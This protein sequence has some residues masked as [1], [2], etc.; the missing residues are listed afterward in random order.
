MPKGF[1][2]EVVA[3]IARSCDLLRLGRTMVAQIE[4]SDVVGLPERFARETSQLNARI[5]PE[6]GEDVAYVAVDGMR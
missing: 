6:L 5:D 1:Q 3:G 4:R 2:D